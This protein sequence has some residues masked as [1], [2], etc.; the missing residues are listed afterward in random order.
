LACRKALIKQ[1]NLEQYR[2][3]SAQGRSLLQKYQKVASSL[4][5]SKDERAIKKIF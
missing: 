2:M 3:G 5:K 4:T 1:N